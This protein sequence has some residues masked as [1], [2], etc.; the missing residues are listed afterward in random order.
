M[1]IELT[2]DW[3]HKPTTTKVMAELVLTTETL[4]FEISISDS[5]NIPL[6]EHPNST[7]NQPQTELWKYDVVEC[8]L[9]SSNDNG[10]PYLE[11][12]LNPSGAWWMMKFN[13]TRIQD[14]A[15]KLQEAQ[16]NLQVIKTPASSKLIIQRNF[17]EAQLNEPLENLSFNITAI[18]NTHSKQQFLTH[19]NLAGKTPD[20]HQPHHFVRVD[21]GVRQKIE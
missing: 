19:A 8:F 13:E 7:L 21:S 1:R 20:F 10:L 16:Q 3:Y 11:L 12:N 5:P 6:T 2:R 14:P 18:I 17:L 9:A 15:F 4:S